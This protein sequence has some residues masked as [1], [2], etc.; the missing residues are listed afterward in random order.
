MGAAF[1][2]AVHAK[3]LGRDVFIFLEA[4]GVSWAFKDYKPDVE[5]H[6]FNPTDF[7]LQCVEDNIEISACRTCLN[8]SNK[9]CQLTQDAKTFDDLIYPG[10]KVGTFMDLQLLLDEPA[11]IF[12]F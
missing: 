9:Y 8:C 3:A 7:F 1:A 6:C 10:I 2:Q 4:K 11:N 5:T 12:T